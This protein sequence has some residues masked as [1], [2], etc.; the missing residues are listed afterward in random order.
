LNVQ[1]GQRQRPHSFGA[2]SEN[3]DARFLLLVAY[4][5]ERGKV[6]LLSS[7]LAPALARRRVMPRIGASLVRRVL[8]RSSLPLSRLCL[9]R[10]SRSDSFLALKPCR[11]LFFCIMC[12]AYFGSVYLC[13]QHL[14]CNCG[15]LACELSQQL[16]LEARALASG[17]S[18]RRQWQQPR[19]RRQQR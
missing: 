8:P 5:A 6:C 17:D 14:R 7:A 11:S 13:A 3:Q 18:T 9:P 10:L 16:K 19:H 4:K 12:V 1:M 15:A 2:T